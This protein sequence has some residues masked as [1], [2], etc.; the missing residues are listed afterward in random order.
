MLTVW[1]NESFEHGSITVLLINTT[2]VY[3]ALFSHLPKRVSG[4]LFLYHYYKEIGEYLC[5]MTL[6]FH[7]T[8][9]F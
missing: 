7:S 5:E 3:S 8:G 4:K 9:T 6:T 2:V 1:T